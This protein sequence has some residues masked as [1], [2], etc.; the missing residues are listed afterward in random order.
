M[1]KGLAILVLLAVGFCA[2]SAKGQGSNTNRSAVPSLI[3]PNGR[4]TAEG[5]MFT[6]KAYEKEALRLVLREA[7]QIAQDLHL[8]ERLPITEADLTHRFVLGYGMSQMK[9]KGIGNVH[10]LD[11]GY[12]VSVNHKM[13]YVESAHYD[14]DCLKLMEQFSWPRERID[15]NGAYQ[16]ATQWLM[17][18]S[19]DVNAL[20]RE[21]QVRVEPEPYWNAR[22]SDRS[23]FLPVYL[24][25]WSLRGNAVEGHGDA[26]LVAVFTPTKKLMS[27]RVEESRYIL[28]EPLSFTNLD[29]LLSSQSGK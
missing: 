20:N 21:C 23:K 16:L 17:A 15:T 26:A 13:S 2:I 3:G 6:T 24:V 11:Y 27:L 4:Y 1:C 5:L 9:P 28:R 8:P 10:T 22:L 14:Q 19:M 25:S 29:V 12:Y 7:N 18:A